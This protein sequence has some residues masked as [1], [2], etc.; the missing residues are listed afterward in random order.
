M[1]GG[2]GPA[3]QPL[4]TRE[5]PLIRHRAL[6]L[7]R[8]VWSTC[9][10]SWFLMFEVLCSCSLRA[11]HSITRKTATSLFTPF[12]CFCFRPPFQHGA[13]LKKLKNGTQNNQL[14]WKSQI[15][16]YPNAPTAKSCKKAPSGRGQTSELD[17]T[18]F[19]QR[20][21]A[22]K[23]ELKREPKLRLRVPKTIGSHKT[24]HP[25]NSKGQ[26]TTKS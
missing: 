12:F 19:S 1:V 18:L 15:N 7:V 5:M 20:P 13:I 4:I 8:R 9:P 24:E 6:R 16:H 2:P 25:Q 14:S 11:P 10:V 3:P 17:N 26:H 21:S 23:A 22:L